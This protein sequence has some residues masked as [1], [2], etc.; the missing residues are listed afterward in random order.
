MAI[1]IPFRERK[2]QRYLFF[3]LGIA[4]FGIIFFVWYTY[5]AKPR[6]PAPSLPSPPPEIKI[7]FEVLEAPILKEFQPFG[8]IPPFEGAIGRENPFIPY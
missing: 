8:E 1:I 7:N 2:K 3:V 4:I 5:F 6:L